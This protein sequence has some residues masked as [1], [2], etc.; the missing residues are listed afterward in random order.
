MKC[1]IIGCGVIAATHAAGYRQIPSAELVSCCD[2]I[3]ERAAGLAKKFGIPRVYTDYRE[4]LDDPELDAVSICTDHA[5]HAEIFRA[6]LEAGKHAICEKVP[7][8]VPEDLEAMVKTAAAHPELAAS[9]IFQHRF[10]PGNIALREVI[11]EGKLGKLLLVNLNFCCLR[12]AE[13]YEHDAWR[14][15]FAGEGGGVLIN[16]AIHF[17][18]QLRFLFG[19]VKRVAARCA[20]H[21]HRGVI[22]TEDTAAFVAEFSGGLFVTAGA[23]NAAAAPWRSAL[24]ITGT[25]AQLEFIDE[26][27][28]HVE[29]RAPEVADRLRER[30]TAAPPADEVQGK[31]YYGTGHTAQLADF[32]AAVAEKRPPAVS[33]ADAANSAALVHA[34]YAAADSGTW[35]I[36]KDYR[37]SGK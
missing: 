31:S 23:T 3:P 33:I 34:V 2:L 18:D 29:S 24:T 26:T 20:N 30:L 22:E 10:N 35:Q 17:L 32:L 36:P 8:R 13:Y 11:R 9:G 25:E 37:S 12:T 28:T 15:T 16:Q 4:M 1:G 19:E 27:L 5:S 7:G 14:G 6:A 21:A